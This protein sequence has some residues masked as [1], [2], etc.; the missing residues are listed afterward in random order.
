MTIPTR[1]DVVAVRSMRNMFTHIAARIG[2]RFNGHF[3]IG[4]VA[5]EDAFHEVPGPRVDVDRISDYGGVVAYTYGYVGPYARIA[6]GAA[7]LQPVTDLT[8]AF[9]NAAF[10][11]GR[12]ITAPR[13]DVKASPR[14]EGLSWEKVSGIWVEQT[15]PIEAARVGVAI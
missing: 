4:L 1:A 12:L 7:A 11:R 14:V 13:A 3:E 15:N 6:F 9:S 8:V 5:G 10:Y 2:Y